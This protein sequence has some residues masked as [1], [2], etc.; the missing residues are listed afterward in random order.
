ML[1]SNIREGCQNQRGDVMIAQGKTVWA[2][3]TSV[4]KKGRAR[5]ENANFPGAIGEGLRH[6]HGSRPP[7]SPRPKP[8]PDGLTAMF[9]AGKFDIAAPRLPDLQNR[10]WA[11][12]DDQP[13]DPPSPA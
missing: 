8:I 12:S 4:G 1:N 13:A 2:I 7:V 6:K 3:S 10:R 5:A 9:D 11:R